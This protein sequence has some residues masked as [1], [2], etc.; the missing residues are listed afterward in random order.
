[1]PKITIDISAEERAVLI[2]I[3]GDSHR[4]VPI[5]GRF[6]S[7]LSLEQDLQSHLNEYPFTDEWLVDLRDFID[8]KLSA[9]QQAKATGG[10]AIPTPKGRGFAIVNDFPLVRGRVEVSG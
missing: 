10:F 4:V 2:R 1:M 9:R 3:D 5:T 7:V 8:A 6:V